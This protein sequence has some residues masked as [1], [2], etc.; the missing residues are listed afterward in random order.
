MDYRK[1]FI[2][3]VEKYFE[4]DKINLKHNCFTCNKPIKKDKFTLSFFE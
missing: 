2:L 4:I 3:P 1:T